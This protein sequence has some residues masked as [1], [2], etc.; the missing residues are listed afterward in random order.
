MLTIAFLTPT[1]NFRGSCV[2]IRDYAIYNESLLNNKSIIITDQKQQS[3]EIAFQWFSKRF[4]V[5]KYD[6][7]KSLNDILIREKINILYVIKY[8]TNDGVGNHD[9]SNVKTVIHCVFD[10]SEPHGDVYAGVS[11]SL[12][13]KYGSQLYV[14]HIVSTIPTP[15]SDMR[16]ELGI[17]QNSIV[18]GRHGGKDTFNLEWAKCIF[19]RIVRERTDIYFIFMNADKFDD[20]PQIIILDATTDIDIKKKFIRTCDAMVVPESLGHTFGLS[21]SEF[22]VHNKPIV[23]YN[24]PVWNTC[25]I[26]ILS[27][28]G[29]YFD[30]PEQLYDI[31]TTFDKSEYETGDW[32]SYREYTPEN[33]MDQFKRIFI[34]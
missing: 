4:P 24:G 32:N 1:I 18:F 2:A 15:G 20:H 6:T 31:I 7:R 33:V 23:C 16:S 13:K 3:D 22:S 30:N 5:I 9:I 10:M 8:G 11:Q 27:D 19:S 29:I 28:K 14:P 25:H 17:P 12:A 34:D 21:C 26:D